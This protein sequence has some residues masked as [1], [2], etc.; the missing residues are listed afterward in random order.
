M[1]KILIISDSILVEPIINEI[2][3]LGYEV[4]FYNTIDFAE[5]IISQEKFDIIFLEYKES[6]KLSDEE[7]FNIRHFYHN[8]YEIPIYVLYEREKNKINIQKRNIFSGVFPYTHSLNMINEFIATFQ[9][10]SANE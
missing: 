7:V 5:E 8:P 3:A 4:H 10:L 1:L 2:E 6:L 9:P